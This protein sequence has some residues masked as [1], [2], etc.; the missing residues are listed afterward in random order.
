MTLEEASDALNGIT[1]GS[2]DA[3]LLSAWESGRKRTGIKNRRGLCQLYRERGE[4]LFAH[5]DGAENASALEASGTSVVV[6]VLNRYS[7]LLEAMVEV[8]AGAREQLVVTGSRSREKSYLAAIET[9]VAQQPDLVHFRVLYGPPR[10]EALTA[11]L[12]RLL[13][14]RDPG[15]RRNGQKTLHIGMVEPSSAMERFFVASETAAVVPLPSFHGAE[16]FDCGVLLS[17]EAAVGL[18][19]H[20]KEACASARPLETMAA[21]RALP[22]RQGG[23]L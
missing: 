23:A 16:G 15:E 1:G 3:S 6:R 12:V 20:G 9:A 19:Q 2:T 21:V 18:L 13:E 7:D 11:H 10:H 14:L 5:Q 8:A 22:H 17:R 4:I